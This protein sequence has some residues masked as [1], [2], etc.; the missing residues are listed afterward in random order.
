MRKYREQKTHSV[1]CEQKH[2]EKIKGTQTQKLRRGYTDSGG[3][4]YRKEVET[5]SYWSDRTED[6]TLPTRPP[7][8][9]PST[10]QPKTF[11][12]TGTKSAALCSQPQCTN[13]VNA[14]TPNRLHSSHKPLALDPR[15]KFLF[16]A[17]DPFCRLLLPTLLLST[18]ICTPGRPAANGGYGSRARKSTHT[19]RCPNH[20]ARQAP[21]YLFSNFFF[22]SSG[23]LIPQIQ[24]FTKKKQLFPVLMVTIPGSMA[25]P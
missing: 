12:T 6:D 4:S 9:S 17:M 11:E 22:I 19:G 8:P 24:S 14:R 25:S 5:I 2:N 7:L 15:S 20:G 21:F 1:N 10:L 18:S 23:N 13:G 16:K 3:K